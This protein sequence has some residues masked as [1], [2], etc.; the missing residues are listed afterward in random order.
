[1]YCF[2]FCCIKIFVSVF[3][4][5]SFIYYSFTLKYLLQKWLCLRLRLTLFRI[6]E[7]SQ[8]GSMVP[9]SRDGNKRCCSISQPLTWQDSSMRMVQNLTLERQIKKSWLLWMHEITLTSCVATMSST[10]WKI[11]SITSIVR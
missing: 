5:F 1:M 8:K 7:R 11:L 9:I 10:V 2:R 3:K 6:T 4:Y